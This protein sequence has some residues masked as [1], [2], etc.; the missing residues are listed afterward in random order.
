MKASPVLRLTGRAIRQGRAA[1]EALV[2][3]RRIGFLGG[4]DPDSAIVVEPGHPLEGQCIA[5]RILVFPGGKGSTVGS[6]TLLR[7]ADNGLAPAALLSEESDAIVAVGAILADIPMLDH[8]DIRGF[9]SGDWVAV[10]G[11]QVEVWRGQE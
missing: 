10:L 3:S 11:E 8:L 2:S 4:V 1:G 9:Q 7:L 6:Y 5:G